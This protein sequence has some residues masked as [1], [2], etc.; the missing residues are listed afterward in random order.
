MKKS[1]LWLLFLILLFVGSYYREVLFRSVNALIAGEDFFYAKTTYL[2]F[3]EG[4]NKAKLLKLK[5]GMTVGFSVFFM[6]ASLLGLK[7][8][9]QEKWP[10][11]ILLAIYGLLVVVAG[12]VAVFGIAFLSFSEVYP[13]LR[14]FIGWIHSPILYLILS[15]AYLGTSQYKRS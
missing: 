10:F 8:S 11:F 1:L 2:P 3:L 14:M 7:F 5:Y 9:F 12:V 13:I 6:G 4:W 15:A